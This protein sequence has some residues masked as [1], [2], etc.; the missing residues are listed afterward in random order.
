[1]AGQRPIAVVLFN[2]MWAFR[3]GMRVYSPL[4]CRDPR[5][6][7]MMDKDLSRTTVESFLLSIASLHRTDLRPLLPQIKI[8]ALG[9]FGGRDIIVSPTQWKPMQAGIPHA[10]IE[11]FP[12]AGH[13]SCWTMRISSCL[14]SKNFWTKPGQL[15][16]ACAALIP[17]LENRPTEIQFLLW[18][19]TLT[20]PLIQASSHI[21]IQIAW[22]GN[23]AGNG[24]NPRHSGVNAV[25]N[26]ANLPVYI[27]DYPPYNQD[28]CFLS[29]I[30]ASCRLVWKPLMGR[31]PA[32]VWPCGWGAPVSSMV[33]ANSAR[34]WPDRPGFPPA[35]AA[36]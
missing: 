32:A 20:F 29:N 4:I 10:Q 35:A 21:T 15:P 17:I 16:D 33:C 13:S 8:P 14:S 7:A 3:M 28:L 5:F 6:P 11:L 22:A 36:D 27:N 34:T 26:Q 18:K 23:I 9:M 25:L 31:A 19:I 12:K 1:M 2:M 30:L 24:R